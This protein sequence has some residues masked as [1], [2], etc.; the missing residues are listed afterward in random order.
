[1]DSY[2]LLILL[3]SM[4][5]MHDTYSSDSSKTTPI[6]IIVILQLIWLLASFH[7]FRLLSIA[8]FSH[9]CALLFYVTSG[10][11]GGISGLGVG[12]GCHL[13]LHVCAPNDLAGNFVFQ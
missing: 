3:E 2:A 8:T 5:S 4:T 12:V 6:G 10:I 11:S 9:V 7:V 1:M 13:C